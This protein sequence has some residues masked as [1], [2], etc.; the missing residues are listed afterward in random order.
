MYDWFPFSRPGIGFFAEK[1]SH[2][3]LLLKIKYYAFRNDKC[4]IEGY[5]LRRAITSILDVCKNILT[6]MLD[7][8]IIYLKTIV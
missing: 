6:L 4:F 2:Y 7:N 1:A 5:M 3:Y 8:C